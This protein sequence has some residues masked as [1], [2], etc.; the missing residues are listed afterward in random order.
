MAGYTRRAAYTHLNFIDSNESARYVLNT[1]YAISEKIRKIRDATNHDGRKASP[2]TTQSAAW[3]NIFK[4]WWLHLFTPEKR[5]SRHENGVNVISPCN[6]TLRVGGSGELVSS[7]HLHRHYSPFSITIISLRQ[8]AASPF[9][10][11][12]IA[13]DTFWR[14]P[15]ERSRWYDLQLV[16]LSV[17]AFS[18]FSLRQ[19]RAFPLMKN[20]LAT[21]SNKYFF[22][23]DLSC[24]I[25]EE[26]RA[27]SFG[28]SEI[29]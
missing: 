17:N 26:H 11:T 4:F 27:V 19:K 8:N 29:W 12:M 15:I 3:R 23:I 18:S 9:S 13:W 22:P 2:Q 20:F 10:T 16:S 14:T 21:S 1:L 5:K 6:Y 28:R 24:L 25:S 7:I